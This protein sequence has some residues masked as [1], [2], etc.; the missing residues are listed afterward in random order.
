VLTQDPHEISPEEIKD[1]E[2]L[3]TVVGGEIAYKKS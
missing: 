2:V 1:L 3:M